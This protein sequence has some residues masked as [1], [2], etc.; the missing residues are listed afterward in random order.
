MLY[1][2]GG[3]TAADKRVINEKLN[4]QL[5]K[6][7]NLKE[8]MESDQKANQEKRR[9]NNSVDHQQMEDDE[10]ISIK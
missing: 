3:L 9:K 8:F 10:I 7:P 2:G 6:I 1:R 4:K 5:M